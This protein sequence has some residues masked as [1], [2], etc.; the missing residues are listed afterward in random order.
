[1]KQENFNLCRKISV[2]TAIFIFLSP[3]AFTQ[4][5]EQSAMRQYLFPAFNVGS[6][7]TKTGNPKNLILNYNTITE[8]MVFEQKGQYYDLIGQASVDTIF[9]LGKKFIPYGKFFLEVIW[10]DKIS[11]GIQH[12]SSLHAPGKPV[13]YGGTSELAASDYLSGVELS[14][15]YYN[16]KLPNEYVVKYS[17]VNWVKIGDTWER[18]LTIKQFIKLFPDYSDELNQFIKKN[19]IKFDRSEDL[20][21]LTE[22]SNSLIK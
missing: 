10:Q 8:K 11:L 5:E 2:V 3:V 16:L 18:F 20:I 15:G 4:E 17:P 19:R 12:R 22:Y 14:S 9:L 6:V 7:K 13:G 21:K 1:M